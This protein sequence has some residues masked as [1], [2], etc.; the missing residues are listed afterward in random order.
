MTSRIPIFKSVIQTIDYI[1]NY[2]TICPT[3]S[4]YS[5]KILLI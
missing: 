1:Q 2:I 4:F 5:V 3:H